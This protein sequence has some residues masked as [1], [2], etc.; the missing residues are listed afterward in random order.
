MKIVKLSVLGFCFLIFS[1]CAD[2]PDEAGIEDVIDEIKTQIEQDKKDLCR[3]GF[4]EEWEECDFFNFI[5]CS[6]YDET[7]IGP[8][9]CDECKWVVSGCDDLDS[10]ADE[11]CSGNGTCKESYLFHD[12]YCE[13]DEG[14][15]G[16]DCS[17]TVE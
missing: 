12:I 10:C 13:C 15:D 6:E 3:N 2:I 1:G 11:H 16:A 8:A 9:A 14:F 4:K 7:L 5:S 17:E